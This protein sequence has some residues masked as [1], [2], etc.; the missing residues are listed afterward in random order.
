MTV[1]AFMAKL[2]GI[3]YNYPLFNGSCPHELHQ[4]PEN[5]NK[6]SRDTF[7]YSSPYGSLVKN[8]KTSKN[9]PCGKVCLVGKE[10]HQ[11]TSS[12]T[13]HDSN[14][15]SIQT[16]LDLSPL[17]FRWPCLKSISD[18]RSIIP[19]SGASSATF[20]YLRE[21]NYIRCLPHRQASER[22]HFDVTISWLNFWGHLRLYLFR[23]WQFRRF[24]RFGRV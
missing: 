21:A 22:R 18:N 4:C 6:N 10:Y 16:I 7:K 11:L 20:I 8:L 3:C 13:V 15:K 9:R 2:R 19:S 12:R 1:T 5:Q 24:R 17:A 23:L 14:F